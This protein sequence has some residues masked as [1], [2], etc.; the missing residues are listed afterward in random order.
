[1]EDSELKYFELSKNEELK[2]NKWLSK[3]N[4]KCKLKKKNKP[5]TLTYCFTP[6]GIGSII[7]VKCSCGKSVDLT[8]DEDW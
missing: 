5:R 4:K 2:L 7:E 1:M 6:T 8:C 3:H